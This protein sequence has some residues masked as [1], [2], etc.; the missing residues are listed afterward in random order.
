[1]QSRR[2]MSVVRGISNKHNISWAG[3]KHTSLVFKGF[4]VHLFVTYFTYSIINYSVS[5]FNY[6][7]MNDDNYQTINWKKCGKQRSI[8]NLR[9]YTTA[10]CKFITRHSDSFTSFF[11]Y[12]LSSYSNLYFL[13]FIPTLFFSFFHSHGL[14][15]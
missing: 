1:M 2:T 7:A 14:N 9:Y 3:C 11:V 13:P 12:S 8:F 6:T 15:S 4:C 5:S 10:L